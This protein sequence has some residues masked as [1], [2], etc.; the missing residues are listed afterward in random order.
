MPQE[1]DGKTFATFLLRRF[2]EI[3]L[4]H[5]G[6][7]KLLYELYCPSLQKDRQQLVERMCQ[8]CGLYFCT[9]TKVNEHVNSCHKQPSLSNNT[10]ETYNVRPSRILMRRSIGRSRRSSAQCAKND[11]AE[12]FDL[13]QSTVAVTDLQDAYP[14]VSDKESLANS[15]S[16]DN[17]H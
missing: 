16:E 2:L 7:Y 1:H 17:V 11:D 13:Q 14:V 10:L 6:F 5:E 12:R 9:K 3:T 4:T 8:R 15:W